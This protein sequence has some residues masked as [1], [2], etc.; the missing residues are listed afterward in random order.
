MGK[1]FL[2]YQMQHQQFAY[3]Y[4]QKK[5]INGAENIL[6]PGC[7]GGGGGG[8]SHK[9]VRDAYWKLHLKL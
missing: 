1:Y 9:M 2:F 7:W 4:T 6:E 8:L 5:T 3:I